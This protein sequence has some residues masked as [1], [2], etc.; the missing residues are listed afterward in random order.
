VLFR[1]VIICCI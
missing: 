1:T